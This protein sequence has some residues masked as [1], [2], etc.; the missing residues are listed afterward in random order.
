MFEFDKTPPKVK[1]LRINS[2][3]ENKQYANETHSVG[4]YLTVDEK[5]AKDPIFKIN[6]IEYTEYRQGDADKFQYFLVT[7]LPEN[8]KE[9]ELE[10]TIKVEDEFGNTATFTNK[11]ILN[12]VGYDKVIFDTT[13]PKLILA[14]TEETNDNVLR[15]ESGTSLTLKDIT[16]K[17]TDASFGEAVNV[18]PYKV[19]FY[20]NIDPGKDYDFLNGL[21]TQ[22]PS[23]NRYHVY[24]RV[25]DYA[26]NTTEDVMLVVMSDT[27]PAT[28]TPN[29]KD[30]LHVEV[31]SEYNHVTA[32]VRDNVD[33]TQI[34]NPRIYLRFDLQMNP[35]GEEYSTINTLIPGKYLAIWDYTDSSGNP[36]TT[37][38]RWVNVT[39]TSTPVVTGVSSNTTYFGSIDFEMTDNSEKFIIYYDFEHN[40]QSCD[41]L[42]NGEHE[43]FTDTTNPFKGPFFITED[44]DNVSVCVVDDSDNKTFFNNIN[45]RKETNNETILNA[46]E[47]GGTIV[48]PENTTL[49]VSKDI[50]IPEGTTIIGNDTT[51]LEG[52]LELK[53]S[54][55][56]LKNI[57]IY[58]NESVILINKNLENIV[59]DGGNYITNNV[60]NQGMGAIRLDGMSNDFEYT[61]D[62]TIKN[63]NI[64]GAIHLL[65]YSGSLKNINKNTITL[66]NNDGV[67]PLAGILITTDKTTDLD[68]KTLLKNQAE[69]NVNYSLNSKGEISY[70]TA[71]QDLNWK[72]V[73]AVEVTK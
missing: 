1:E 65:N 14:G 28:I 45:L 23:G 18:E 39:D 29:Q 4:I 40:Y 51:K 57:N 47:N 33:E 72:N 2:S 44:I 46:I 9:G 34:I 66:T 69:V 11:D 31:G 42:M 17:A 10:F 62:I 7:K 26:G 64:Q 67:S 37:L 70:Y 54:N 20:N 5:L 63:A 30:D 48:L 16:A 38:K 13:D 58:D 52:Q 27:T 56:T 21:D 59:I 12:D 43:V 32:T 3:N 22:K 24:Y 55:I 35:L 15:I 71:I 41:D 60:G 6:G 8:T 36:S 50:N 53:N 68:A 25:T 73:S 19:T 61:N 49:K